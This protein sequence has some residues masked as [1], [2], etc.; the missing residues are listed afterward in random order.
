MAENLTPPNPNAPKPP[1]QPPAA[2]NAPKP[3]AN[4][5]AVASPTAD[6]PATGPQYVNGRLTRAGMEHVIRGGGS[7]SHNGQTLTRID[8]LP[9]EAALAAGDEQAEDQARANI[10]ARRAALDREEALLN[11]KGKGK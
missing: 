8:E 11:R 7:V 9:P 10:D 6:A 5:A 1:P 4:V 3:A 2:P